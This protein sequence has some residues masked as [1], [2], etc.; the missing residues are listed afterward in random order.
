VKLYQSLR[1]RTRLLVILQWAAV[2]LI[3]LFM[4]RM[5]WEDWAR[6]K[7]ASFALKWSPLFW[8]TLIFA[9]SYFIQIWAWYLITVKLGIAVSFRETLESWFYSQLGKYLP[10]KVWMLLGR[11]YLYESKGKSRRAISIALYFETVIG[12]VAAGVL[13]WVAFV[14]Y[15]EIRPFY[16]GRQ[17][18][19]LILPFALAFVFLYPPILERVLNLLLSRLKREPVSVPVSYPALLWILFISL[20]AWMAGGIAFYLFANSLFPVSPRYILLLTG[21]LAISC[22]LGL[23]ALFAPSG[24]GVRE[25]VLVYLLSAIFFRAPW[26]SSCRS[27][28]GSGRP[29]LKSG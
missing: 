17:V 8:A 9:F 1:K 28:P 18:G 19:G 21:S 12:T 6:V 29:S 5:V 15:E 11:F 2:T 20:L 10:G 24:L 23:V 27:S 16:S 13:F 3:F 26:P 14:L 22:F 4:G 25:G 7:G